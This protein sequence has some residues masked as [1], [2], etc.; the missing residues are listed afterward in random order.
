M[1]IVADFVVAVAV[2]NILFGVAVTGVNVLLSN[3]V[4]SVDSVAGA[5]SCDSV[6]VILIA[7][8][9]TGPTVAVPVEVVGVDTV[10]RFSVV[11][12]SDEFAEVAVATSCEGIEFS[13][14][15][16]SEANATV[17][18]AFGLIDVTAAKF[19]ED[20][21]DCTAEIVLDVLV[22]VVAVVDSAGND[23]VVFDIW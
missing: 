5:E 22:G 19:A 9:G 12:A 20:V 2:I 6:D 7:S 21:N 3:K 11:S 4:F 15:I 17:I 8:I 16:N 13:T 10:V 1:I 18:S 14:C 23:V